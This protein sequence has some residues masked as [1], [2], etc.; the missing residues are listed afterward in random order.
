MTKSRTTET[1]IRIILASLLGSSLTDAELRRLSRLFGDDPAFSQELGQRLDSCLSRPSRVSERTLFAPQDPVVDELMKSIK[2]R[3]LSKSEVTR[4]MR[5]LSPKL[6]IQD[7]AATLHEIVID[8][9]SQATVSEI[10]S[11][12]QLL[13]A[14][15]AVEDE[16]LTGIMKRGDK[17]K[18]VGK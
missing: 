1:A 10:N 18:D 12:G 11:L 4:M 6:R 5:M 7:E 14:T 2:R 17:D 15:S 8:F 13:H 3:R 16:Y 9:A